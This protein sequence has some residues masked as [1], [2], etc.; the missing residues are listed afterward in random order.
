MSTMSPSALGAAVRETRHAR[1]LTQAELARLAGVGRRFIVDLE[2][3][4]ARAELGK[5]LQVM[6]TLGL[7]LDL[8]TT[9]VTVVQTPSGPVAFTTSGGIS[10]RPLSAPTRLWALPPEEALAVITLPRSVYWSGGDGVFDLS[11][12]QDREM[13]YRIVL[14]EAPPEVI[15]RFVDGSLLEQMWDEILLPPR[16][17]DAWQPAVDAFRLTLAA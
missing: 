11:D 7:S 3:G 6:R 17:R 1:G 13:A 8:L 12:A 15:V 14:G 5:T 9:P 2:S 10:G 4:H 16:V